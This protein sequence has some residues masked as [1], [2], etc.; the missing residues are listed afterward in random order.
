MKKLLTILGMCAFCGGSAHAIPAL[1]LY[2]EGAVYDVA[3]DTWIGSGTGPVR[4]WTIGNVGDFGA[5]SSVKLAIAYSAA[6]TPTFTLT[7]STTGN[8]GDRK[9]VV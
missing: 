8:Y 1:Q 4:L 7:P 9:S 2:I 5:I 6:D 3:T